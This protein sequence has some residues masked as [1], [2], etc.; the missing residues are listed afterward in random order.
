MRS[1]AI[2][3]TFAATASP[4]HT[5]PPTC[6]DS[7]LLWQCGLCG[8]LLI[9]LFCAPSAVHPPSTP[10]A[11]PPTHIIHMQKY[12]PFAPRHPRGSDLYP[13]S[14]AQRPR[15]LLLAPASRGLWCAPACCRHL[16]PAQRARGSGLGR[17]AAPGTLF[18]YIYIKAPRGVMTLLVRAWCPA[19]DYAHHRSSRHPRLPQL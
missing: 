2:W 7:V 5:R 3:T 13:V 16:E 4:F 14:I 15:I 12:L 6:S 18:I 1:N 19:G 8:G 9:R 17:P 11:P 10:S